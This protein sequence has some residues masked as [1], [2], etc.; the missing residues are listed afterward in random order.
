[1][2]LL[3]YYETAEASLVWEFLNP[4]PAIVRNQVV[5]GLMM[6][7][8]KRGRIRRAVTPTPSTLHTTPCT[9]NPSQYT[10][11]PRP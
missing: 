9:L 7:K 10:L 8:Y 1:M 2:R 11:N 6:L 4:E 3:L 5:S